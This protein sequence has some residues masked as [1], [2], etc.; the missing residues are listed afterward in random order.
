[1]PNYKCTMIFHHLAPGA[2]GGFAGGVG[3]RVAGWSESWYLVSNSARDALELMNNA[4]GLCESRAALLST[5]GAIIGQRVQQVSPVGPVLIGQAQ[6]PSPVKELADVPQMAISC[7]FSGKAVT[8]RRRISLR[9]VPDARVVGGGYAKAASFTVS[10]TAFYKSLS[11]YSFPGHDR[12]VPGVRILS[13]DANGRVILAAP[14][15][16]PINTPV[17]ITRIKEIASAEIRNFNSVITAQPFNNIVQLDPNRSAVSGIG[18]RM[19]NNTL[20]Y[21]AVDPDDVPTPT[22][23]T[24]KVGRPSDSYRGRR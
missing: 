9:G 20:A 23:T 11:G 21:F 15:V 8:N 22:I 19:D 13:C 6:F 5:S 16:L 24:R 1:M 2:T 10:L 17:R 12:S 3:S 7:V 14:N 18:G 4:N